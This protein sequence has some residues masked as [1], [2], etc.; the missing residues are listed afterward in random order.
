VVHWLHGSPEPGSGPYRYRYGW[1]RLHFP[2]H[3]IEEAQGEVLHFR[4]VQR[5]PDG[6]TLRLANCVIPRS[7]A[8]LELARQRFTG[9]RSGAASPSAGLGVASSRRAAATESGNW[10]ATSAENPVV[11]EEVVGEDCKFYRNEPHCR[12]DDGDP[13]GDDWEDDP[14]EGDP[15]A[16]GCREGGADEGWDSWS[17]GG[18]AYADDGVRSGTGECPTCYQHEDHH[19]QKY[20]KALEKIDEEK[21]PELYAKA[22]EYASTFQVW[23]EVRYYIHPVTNQKRRILGEWLPYGELGGEPKEPTTS[24]FWETHLLHGSEFPITV[25]HEAAH[26]IGFS[27]ENNAAEKYARSCMR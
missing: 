10:L 16:P 12:D 17:G 1:L 11:L 26:G 24:A 18:G 6:T 7:R 5:A 3:V 8:A 13:W 27:D 19:R 2:R 23:K 25:A 14:C 4:Y 20:N 9:Q 15:T 22:V 21:C